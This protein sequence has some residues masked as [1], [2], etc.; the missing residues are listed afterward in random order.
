MAGGTPRN[1]QTHTVKTEPDQMIEGSG[2]KL[3]NNT[4]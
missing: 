3:K 4:G 2:K 1:H